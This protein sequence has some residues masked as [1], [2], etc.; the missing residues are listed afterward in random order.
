MGVESRA[1]CC[2]FGVIIRMEEPESTAQRCDPSFPRLGGISLPPFL[3][4]HV[5][6]AYFDF[7]ER[8]GSKVVNKKTIEALAK[9]G[10]F[11]NIHNNR[12]QIHDSCEVLSKY[13]A[14]IQEEKNSS[15][16]S[17]F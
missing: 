16:M 2:D 7:V 5:V 15:Q 13:S 17:L 4:R 1:S 14:S 6:S 3:C 10:A 9:A 8:V 11:D 12:K